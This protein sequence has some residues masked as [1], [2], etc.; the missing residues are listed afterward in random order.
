MSHLRKSSFVQTFQGVTYTEPSELF[1]AVKQAENQALSLFREFLEDNQELLS[2]VARKGDGNCGELVAIL[3]EQLGSNFSSTPAVYRKKK[4]DGTLRRQ[5]FE[6]D[7]YR[8]VACGDYKNLHCDHKH[9]ESLG[10]ET[11]LDNLQT[12]C[13]ACNLSKGSSVT[14][15]GRKA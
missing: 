1:E 5:V 9:P 10:G 7:A 13:G 11:T 6:R 15:E 2:T 3:I 12:L 14:W 4:I 8:C